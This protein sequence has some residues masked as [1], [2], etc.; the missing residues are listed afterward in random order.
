MAKHSLS[1]EWSW[2]VLLGYTVFQLW[3]A[4]ACVFFAHEYAHSFTAWVLGA[5]SNPFALHYP[6]PTVVVLLIQLGINQNVDEEALFASGH[7]AQAAIIAAAGMILGNALISF[8]LSRWGY[9]WAKKAGSRGWAMF[10][11]WATVASVGN[12]L[13]YVPVRTFTSE[14]DMG[15]VQRG[16]GWSPWTILVVLGIPTLLAL[17]YFFAR[18]EPAT[19]AWLFPRSVAKRSVFAILTA[20]AIFGFY[21][22]AGLLE[23]GPI[24]HKLSVISVTLIFPL[25][26]FLGAMLVQREAASLSL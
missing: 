26:G 20:F 22:A 1:R 11:Y 5:K 18:V 4:H 2:P 6:Q 19:L 3:A 10:A 16:F 13:D 8:S 24:S 9:A 17:I 15:S 25:M 12:F 23:G 14:G 21:G 7:G